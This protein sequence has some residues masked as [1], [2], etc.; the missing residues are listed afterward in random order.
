M[1]KNIYAILLA[2][3]ASFALMS[4]SDDDPSSESIFPTTSPKRDAFDKWLLENYTFPYNVEMKYKMEDIESD[5][6]Y[7]LV[8]ADSAKTAKLSIIMKYLWFDAY[9]EVVGPDFIKENMPRTI[10][11]IGSP[12]Y[13][14]EGTM[15]LGTAEGGLKITLYM[16][17]SLDDETLKDYDTMN[18]YYFHTLHHEF[19]HILNQKIP[20]DQS[21][22]LITE[23]GYVSGDWYLISDKTAHQAGFITPYAMVEPLEDFAEML[24]GY[25]TKSQSEWNAILADAGTTGAASISAKLDIVRNYMQ[26]SWNVDIEQL[27]AAVLRRANTLSAVDLE[28]LN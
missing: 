26:E 16:V 17:N 22:K 19:T 10:H 18:E 9:N 23:S 7:H 20:Y 1:K 27:R 2:F 21:Y 28:H 15:V 3:V 5:M 6:K 13:N 8:P 25:V 24:S 4:C 14:S 12:A 11:F